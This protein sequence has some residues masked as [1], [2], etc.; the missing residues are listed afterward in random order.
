VGVGV[1]VWV[2]V[3]DDG[4]ALGRDWVRVNVGR[5]G[6]VVAVGDTTSV[7]LMLFRLVG[8]SE[9]LWLSEPCEGVPEDWLPVHVT[10]LY[11]WVRL[12]VGVMEGE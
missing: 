10:I 12:S 11:V 5:V 8:E 4:V 7:Q 6:V 9:E 3:G 2:A 1:S